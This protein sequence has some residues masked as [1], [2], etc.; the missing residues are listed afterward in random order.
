MFAGSPTAHM[1]RGAAR[2]HALTVFGRSVPEVCV[3]GGVLAK[4]RK[5][6]LFDIDVPGRV[7]FRE[8]AVL[9]GGSV[10]TVVSIPNTSANFGLSICY[11]V[12]FPE[13]ALVQ[14]ARGMH[15]LVLPGAF[16]LTTGPAHWELL[17]R[18]RA[19]DCQIYVAACS[20]V[21]APED[22]DGYKAWGHSMVVDPWGTV[23][24]SV[25]EGEE[26]VLA[27][28]DLSLIE[29]TRTNIPTSMQKRPDIYTVRDTQ[30]DNNNHDQ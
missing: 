29:Q 5:A 2:D 6:H 8:S 23:V 14:R 9:S 18:A 20:P 3:D 15:V 27:D 7:S 1:L 25:D 21:R 4:H 22:V 16:N 11:D 13:L 10:A 17:L 12:R 24:A 30:L 26:I 28:I 19:V